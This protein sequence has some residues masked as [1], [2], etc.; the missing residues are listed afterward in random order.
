[1]LQRLTQ[2]LRLL[3][4]KYQP[5]IEFQELN[6]EGWLQAW[7]R[8]QIQPLILDTVPIHTAKT[9]A[10]EVRVLT[11]RRDWLN[12]IWSLKS[13]YHYAQV[14]YP[15]YIHDG[16]LKP[17]QIQSLKQHF[18][19]A[20]VITKT[21]ADFLVL[22]ELQKRNLSRLLAYRDKSP[23]GRRLID[24]YL[25]SQ[26]KAV[27]TIDADILFFKKPVELLSFEP[28]C[29]NKYN[30]D[31]EYNYS[32][33]LDE[34]NNDLKICP[35]SLINAGLS[36]VWLKSVNLD[37]ID[38]WL[39]HPKLFEESWLTEQTIHAL[40]STIYGVELLPLTY[41]LSTEAG[42]NNES[43]AKHYPS[44]TAFLYQ[45]GMKKLIGM[46]FIHELSSDSPQL[47]KVISPI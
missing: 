11:W 38:E 34:I 43:V 32:I 14:D 36:L 10:I 1:M 41:Q 26:A 25:V 29:P 33:G 35:I 15:L 21:E 39:S 24:F 19:D 18:P 17:N 13:F 22:P 4:R 46:G 42:L 8:W 2:A 20:I 30:Q 3:L 28:D 45:E 6:R 7:Q 16:G 5:W 12:T 23:F 27:I 31:R 9:G 47:K 37:K 40:F 44:R